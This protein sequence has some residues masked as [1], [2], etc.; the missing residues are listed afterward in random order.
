MRFAIVLVLVSGCA[1]LVTSG[2][3][4][5]ISPR[6]EGAIVLAT[7][8][9]FAAVAVFGGDTP[10]EDDWLADPPEVCLTSKHDGRIVFG[11]LAAVDLF[12]GLYQIVRNEHIRGD[13]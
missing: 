9:A 6:T 4:P 7:G 11:G 2:F 5:R 1:S 13:N 12:T 3:K 8:L 10:C